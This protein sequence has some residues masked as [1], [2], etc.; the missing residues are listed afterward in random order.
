MNL[1]FE[2]YV[3]KKL[4]RCIETDDYI[5]RKRKKKKKKKKKEEF[6]NGKVMVKFK[7]CMHLEEDPS[8]MLHCLAHMFI[9]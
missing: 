5:K 2:L 7:Q 4:A 8:I 1:F 6:T 9:T 3:L